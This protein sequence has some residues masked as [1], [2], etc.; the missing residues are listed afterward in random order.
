MK[1][2]L[3]SILMFTT[4]FAQAQTVLN[5]TDSKPVLEAVQLALANQGLY[6]AECSLKGYMNKDTK[7]SIQTLVSNAKTVRIFEGSQPVIIAEGLSMKWTDTY[8]YNNHTV[9]LK[10]EITTDSTLTEIKELVAVILPR[11]LSI[12]RV[13]RGTLT[14]PV[15][16][17]VPRYSS[18]TRY[19]CL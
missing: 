4:G 10:L 3:F 13:N 14:R 9:L 19:D 11:Q 15:I 6:H 2:V 8:S 12:D 17:E 7:I 16:V 1:A 5:E 18:E